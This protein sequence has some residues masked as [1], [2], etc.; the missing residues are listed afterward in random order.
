MWSF[1][2]TEGKN[3]LV[4]RTACGPGQWS[5]ANGDQGMRGASSGW[6]S[7]C[8]E[9]LE[10]G[11]WHVIVDKRKLWINAENEKGTETCFRKNMDDLNQLS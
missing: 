6:E 7:T 3:R 11:R 8:S 2:F 5:L 10:G 1:P 4:S 9:R